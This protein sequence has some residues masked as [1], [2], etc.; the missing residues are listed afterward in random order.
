VRNKA[1]FGRNGISGERES[2]RAGGSATDWSVRNKANLGAC[3]PGAGVAGDWQN[4]ANWPV[5]PVAGIACHPAKPCE[6]KPIS[7]GHVAESC[8]FHVRACLAMPDRCGGRHAYASVGMAP[9]PQSLIPDGCL[10]F[11]VLPS[12][13]FVLFAVREPGF[14]PSQE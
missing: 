4:K 7:S 6:T 13:V 5:K 11:L 8:G 9:S 12:V 10:R 2:L 1:K 14:P 3:W